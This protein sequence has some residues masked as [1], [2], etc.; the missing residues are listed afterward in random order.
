MS[1]IMKNITIYQESI[2]LSMCINIESAGCGI[3]DVSIEF[4]PEFQS[5]NNKRTQQDGATL[6]GS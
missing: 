5:S 3:L 2:R 6:G 4:V 1:L